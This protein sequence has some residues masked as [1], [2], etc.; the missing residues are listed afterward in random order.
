MLRCGM[1]VARFNFSHG[2]HE[3][4]QGTLDNLR[5]ACRETRIMC[6]VML[7]TKVG[8]VQVVV[9]WCRCVGGGG[10]EWMVYVW[11]GRAARGDGVVGGADWAACG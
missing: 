1:N 10:V 2:S 9:L 11:G 5:A 3:Y 6:A 8:A 4:H 7:D